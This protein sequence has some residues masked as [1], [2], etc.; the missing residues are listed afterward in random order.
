MFS[1]PYNLTAHVK[2]HH[3]GII[4]PRREY[5]RA[6]S[7]HCQL[8]GCG[9]RFDRESRLVEHMRTHS[10]EKPFQCDYN[11]FLSW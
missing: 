4:R 2:E 3:E 1:M 5:S 11:V 10:G 7:F 6:L 8:P 9:K